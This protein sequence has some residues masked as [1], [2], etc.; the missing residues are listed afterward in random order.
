[1][2]PTTVIISKETT[3]I[4]E[5][6]ST[7][8]IDL[9]VPA[10]V[11]MSG[12]SAHLKVVDSMGRNV[13]FEKT[14]WTINGQEMYVALDESDTLGKAGVHRYELVVYNA[15]DKRVTIMR[16]PFIIRATLIKT[17]KHS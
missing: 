3:I 4:R 17:A 7:S 2:K 6:G 5:E 15:V 12:L 8:T 14:N 1:M 9:T 11:S 10:T 13:V 16:G